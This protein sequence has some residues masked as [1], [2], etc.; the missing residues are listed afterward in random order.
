MSRLHIEI[1]LGHQ[2]G[3]TIDGIMDALE[4]LRTRLDED[5]MD[6]LFSVRAGESQGTVVALLDSDGLPCGTAQVRA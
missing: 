5:G 4:N 1:D 3:M 6:D 2:G